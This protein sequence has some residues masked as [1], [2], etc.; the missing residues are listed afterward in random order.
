MTRKETIRM[1][2]ELY[3][4]MTLSMLEDY[5][6]SP[7]DLDDA[8]DDVQAVPIAQQLLRELDW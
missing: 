8:T 5:K 3:V 2:L 1:A 4:E 6:D 7:A